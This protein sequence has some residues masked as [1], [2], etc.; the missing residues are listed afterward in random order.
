MSAGGREGL[1]LKA[2][3]E[4]AVRPQRHFFHDIFE[5]DEVFDVEVGLVGEVFGGG[6]EVDVEAGAFVEAE[7]LDQGGAE[8]CLAVVG[9][10]CWER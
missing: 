4:P 5:G 9:F 2:V 10:S 6:V 7:M 1:L 8:G 3:D